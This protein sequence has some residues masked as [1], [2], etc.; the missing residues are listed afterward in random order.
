M[1]DPRFVR[2]SFIGIAFLLFAMASAAEAQTQAGT[3]TVVDLNGTWETRPNQ[4]LIFN[5]P[6]AQ[7][8][9]KPETVPQAQSSLIKP[10]EISWSVKPVA[11]S[12]KAGL[13]DFASKTNISAWYRR[14]FSMPAKAEGKTASLIFDCMLTKSVVW[15]NGVKLGECIF[16]IAPTS[17]DIGDQ[18][19]WGG[20][21]E[22]VIGLAGPEALVDLTNELFV[23]QY[24]HYYAGIQGDVRVEIKSCVHVDD[25]YVKTSV[26]QKRIEA[27]MTLVNSGRAAAT[28]VPTCFIERYIDRHPCL[29][30]MGEPV[31]LAAGETKTVS[32]A[33]DWA[34]PVLWSPETP[35]L[36]VA[37]CR[38]ASQKGAALDEINQRFGFREFTVKGRQFLLNGKPITLFRGEAGSYAN[39]T[40]QQVYGSEDP[41]HGGSLKQLAG[42]SY[43]NYRIWGNSPLVPQLGDEIGVTVAPTLAHFGPSGFPLDPAKRQLWLPNLKEHLRKVV[44]NLRNHPSIVIWNM[45]NETYWGDVPTN[46]DMKAVC[47][48]LVETVRSVDPLRPLD[49]DAEVG[50]DGL[51]DVV[52]LHCYTVEGGLS[53]QYANSGVVV[54]NDLYWIKD[55][56]NVRS[57]AEFDW[58]KPLSI[59]EYAMTPKTPDGYS[60]YGGE[61]SYNWVKESMHCRGSETAVNVSLMTKVSDIY[62]V[63][64]VACL[65]PWTFDG[66]DVIPRFA[67][68]PLD[69][70]PNLQGG[71]MAVRK[72][73]VFYESDTGLGNPRL[74]CFLTVAGRNVWE[75]NIP[76]VLKR[77]ANVVDVPITPPMVDRTAKAELTL[78]LRYDRNGSIPEKTR[79]SETVFIMPEAS[80]SDV[81]AAKIALLDPVGKTAKALAQ[82]SLNLKPLATLDSAALSG[83]KVLLVAGDAP[84]APAK[85]ELLDFAAKGGSVVFLQRDDAENLGAGFPELDRRH[86]A[87]RVWKRSHSHPALD[88]LD[89]GQLSY[90]RPDNLVGKLNY[91]KPNDGDCK[92]LL[93]AGGLR[94]MEWTPLCETAY[95]DGHLVFS[96]LSL[97]D[98]LGVE[99][100][101]GD[102]LSRLVR[103]GLAVTPDRTRQMRLLEQGNAKLEETLGLCRIVCS[104]GLAG[105]GP[106]LWDASYKASADELSALKTYLAAGGKVWLHGFTPET[107][108]AVAPLLP[109]KPELAA[110]DPKLTTAVRMS[111]SSLMDNLSSADFMWANLNLWDRGGFLGGSVPTAKL[112]SHILRLPAVDAGEPLVE[113]G[114]LV[115]IPTGKG[116]VLFDTLAWETACATEGERVTR[117]V[118]ALAMNLGAKIA[119]P[120]GDAYDYFPVDLAKFANMGYVDEVAEDGQGGGL[121][122]G[123]FDLCF[124][125][126]NHTERVNGTGEPV[127]AEPFP[128][129]TRFFGVPF[130]L[131]APK[132]N[133]GKAMI[134]LRATDRALKLP[135]KVVGVPVGRK[136][137]KLWFIHAANYVPAKGTV[138][139]KYLVHYEDGTVVEFPLRSGIEINDWSVPV[140]PEKAR[141]CW[142]GNNRVASSVGLFLAEW[143][144]PFPARSIQSI[145]IVGALTGA[146]LGVVGIAGGV[147]KAAAIAPLSRWDFS[148]FKDGKVADSVGGIILSLEKP[149][150]APDPV[151]VELNGEAALKI[152][153]QCFEGDLGKVAFDPDKPF[154]TKMF[155]S[156]V[157]LPEGAP[158]NYGLFESSPFR[159]GVDAKSMTF[160]LEYPRVVGKGTILRGKTSLELGKAYEV[161][162]VFDASG[163]KLYLNG[164]LEAMRSGAMTPPFKGGF[165]VGKNSGSGNLSGVLRSVELLQNKTG[166]SKNDSAEGATKR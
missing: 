123:P 29:A 85:A 76:L 141:I 151:A 92:V 72:V 129:N 95:G 145:D 57:R 166:S 98:R 138:I 160:W 28:V 96:Q 156:L 149:K 154:T 134:A 122:Q 158:K 89:D 114:L 42:R 17:Y 48:E 56:A 19:R 21:N 111:D 46:P 23:G 128:E 41:G 58:D 94:G 130:Q 108:G 113:P 5:F 20:E 136:A 159:I 161:E 143:S 22:L 74:Q 34:N 84:L 26:A 40:Y 35:F 93:D 59:G 137:D 157:A 30:I 144:N 120:Q 71:K 88:G 65:G 73:V 10:S 13:T 77:G 109:F 152:D 64:G 8:G 110:I 147:K 45:A 90:W 43:N 101:A 104:K 68:H 102:I 14:K 47:K 100:V 2:S 142:T 103:Y 53:K 36:Y 15:L 50:W 97:V 107:V 81:D 61:E 148:E 24:S 51:L 126:T 70:H 11:E 52:S 67:I 60:G 37:S 150:D 118:S 121:D 9:W 6:P 163:A 39:E 83:K 162:I 117:I 135:D 116:Q 44:K 165:S 7:D 55:K 80:L 12:K 131:T 38:L 25:V 16:G 63:Q 79:H 32:V 62:R 69:F 3:R 1:I 105:D 127:A 82:I 66:T 164:K 87:S 91:S 125:L 31:T 27:E 124:F 33:R 132:K 139:G 119:K 4:G 155:F 140:K 153:G 112:G 86:V 75:T 133:D 54:P 146:Q 78:R 115:A 18:V 106:V 99:P 49:G